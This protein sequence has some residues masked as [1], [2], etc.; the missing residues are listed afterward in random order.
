MIDPLNLVTLLKDPIYT[1]SIVS[2]LLVFAG[3]S[4]LKSIRNG[5]PL[6]PYILQ[7]A[8]LTFILPVVLLMSII[9]KIQNE[10]VVGIIGTIVGYIFG[11]APKHIE[12][13]KNKDNS[14]STNSDESNVS[15][16]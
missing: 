15:C 16:S 10:A 7:I 14:I 3:A 11:A 9:L 2:V 6:Q 5:S 8:G 1:A 4:V 13:N 12:M